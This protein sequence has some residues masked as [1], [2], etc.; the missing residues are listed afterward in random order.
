M[1]LYAMLFFNFSFYFWSVV[2]EL[3]HWTSLINAFFSRNLWSKHLV[4][5]KRL[6]LKST[7]SLVWIPNL[8]VLFLRQRMKWSAV[9]YTMKDISLWSFGKQWVYRFNLW[10]IV[11]SLMAFCF[12]CNIFNCGGIKCI[13][14]WII[15]INHCVNCFLGI[16]Y[17][18]KHEHQW[19]Y[20]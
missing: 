4:Y 6:L 11:L 13:I 8:P 12:K 10:P 2:Q 15:L 19:S 9:N 7:K 16:W 17:S 14:Y 5:W 1:V 18:V 20:C 3:E